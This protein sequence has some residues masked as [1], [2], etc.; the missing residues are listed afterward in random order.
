MS[1]GWEDLQARLSRVIAWERRKRREQIMI[2]ALCYAL[3]GALLAQ[4]FTFLLGRHG[5]IVPMVLF[6]VLAPCLF[7]TRRWRD[8]DSA[9]SLA[10]VDKALMLHERATTAWELMQRGRIHG[11]GQLVLHQADERLRRLDHRALFPRAWRW[12]AYL[13]A[14]LFALWVASFWWGSARQTENA[15]GLTPAPLSQ[16][17]REFARRMQEQAQSE[18]LP[19]TLAAGR[20][21]EKL[22][23]RG[24]EEQ[25]TD[26]ELRAEVAGVAKQFAARRAEPAA[27]AAGAMQT[28][29]ELQDLR[30]E[31][32]SARDLLDF[33]EPGGRSWQE[34]LAGLT[35]L[36]KQLDKQNHGG[37]GA[38]SEELKA[39]LDKLEGE[40]SGELDRRA[41][42]EAEQYLQ[43][44]A[45][46]G[47]SQPGEAQARAGA[48]EDGD[49]RGESRPAD[50]SGSAPGEEP[51]MA[52]A[53]EP[54]LPEFRGGA[55]AKIK[56]MPGEGERSVVYFNA[57]PAPGKSRLSQDEI[58]ASYRRQAEAELNAEKIPDELK[59]VVKNYF[60]SLDRENSRAQG[61]A[62]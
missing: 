29:Q 42:L 16:K 13:L 58:I 43:Q 11:M 10:A 32:Q 49:T 28:G 25:A 35:Q 24:I 30:A 52:S 45:Q 48:A 23:Q 37:A 54:S 39:L 15:A 40:V 6:A 53:K 46:R 18:G 51:G 3:I 20:E 4:P 19:Q 22:A 26:E 56:G 44:L 7:V 60:L 21:L 34:R 55:R 12:H 47:Q 61:K 57:K 62:P 41:L 27:S 59:D 8:R 9:R 36:Q 17:L 50:S 2:A 14:P 38:T 33:S 31:L 5:W 1:M